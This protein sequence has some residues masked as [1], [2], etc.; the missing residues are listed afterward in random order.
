ME[1]GTYGVVRFLGQELVFGRVDRLSLVFSYVFALLALVGMVY[2]LH[3]DDDAQ[4]VA[5]LTYAGAALGV[6]V[7]GGLPVPVP[8]LGADGAVGRAPRLAAPQTGARSPPD[9]ATFWSMY[10][11][12]CACWEGS[13]STGPRPGRSPSGT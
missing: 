3:V 4:H 2:A 1:P 9:S 12:G 13:C 10:S 11:A 7:R 8:V 6:D 5:A